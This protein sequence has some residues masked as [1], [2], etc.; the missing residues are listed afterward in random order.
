[1][2]EELARRFGLPSWRFTNSGTESTMAAIRIARVYTRRDDVVK[3]FGAYHG[4][5]DFTR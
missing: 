5:H 3:I 4:H 2:A 1:M